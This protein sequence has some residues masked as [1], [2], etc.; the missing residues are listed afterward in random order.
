MGTAI[1][2]SKFQDQCATRITVKRTNPLRNNT[3]RLRTISRGRRNASQSESITNT[4]IG[5]TTFHMFALTREK[6]APPSN[7]HPDNKTFSCAKSPLNLPNCGEW[8]LTPFGKLTNPKAKSFVVER[9]VSFS[10]IQRDTG[11]VGQNTP[12]EFAA[13]C[14]VSRTLS[15]SRS[16]FSA[17]PF[18]CAASWNFGR[19]EAS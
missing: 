13:A 1:R 4:T 7:C 9:A 2:L 5:A 11:F 12:D 10:K 15:S 16:D 8:A 19:S 14:H 6:I 3:V 17:K 18:V